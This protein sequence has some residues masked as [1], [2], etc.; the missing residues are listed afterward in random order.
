MFRLLIAKNELPLEQVAEF[1]FSDDAKL[2]FDFYV[3]QG[4]MRVQVVGRGLWYSDEV[5]YNK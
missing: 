5:L 4:Y 3:N 1:Q 2:L